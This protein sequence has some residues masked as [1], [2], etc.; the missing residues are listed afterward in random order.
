MQ[1]YP[2]NRYKNMNF[3]KWPY[4]IK[5]GCIAGI[6]G[7]AIF[8]FLP[9]DVSNLAF[10]PWWA[11]WL[12]LPAFFLFSAI[13]IVSGTDFISNTD[14]ESHLAL[15]E[16]LWILS[17]FITLFVMGSLIGFIVGKIKP[18]RMIDSNTEV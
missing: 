10:T 1:N 7:T 3:K 5:G 6:I 4:W 18:K 2:V 17:I 16:N 14:S 8:L 12:I 15:L 9:E 13:C 11:V